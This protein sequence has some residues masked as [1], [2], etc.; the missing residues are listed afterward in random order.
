M[1]HEDVVLHART[2]R[3]MFAVLLVQSEILL[4]SAL[5][6]C[7]GTF[8]VLEGI[9][10]SGT[11]TQVEALGRILRSRGHT[12][13]ETREPT[14]LELGRLLRTYLRQPGAPAAGMALLFAAD[15]AFHVANVIA[16]ALARGEVVLC[17]RYVMSSWVY[18][19]T[20]CPEDWVR[21]INR[22]A[23]WPDLT[24]VLDVPANIGLERVARRAGERDIYETEPIQV[25]VAEGYRRLL[26]EDLSGVV[27]ID[28]TTS[29]DSVTQQLQHLCEG[30]G[31]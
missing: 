13:V 21:S 12:V 20:S 7:H 3:A 14:D 9:D 23:P 1:W 26:A 30:L 4:R 29:K 18:Q 25:R 5:V 8:I 31:L 15:R 10:G 22:L 6:M 19:A 24:V 27:A 2:I 11:T 16:P 28:G 17:D